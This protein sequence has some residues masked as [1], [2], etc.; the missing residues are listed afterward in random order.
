L[1]IRP[2]VLCI[3]LGKDM[4]F[5]KNK[6]EISRMKYYAI[7]IQKLERELGIKI[8]SFPEVGLLA[9]QFF[10]DNP[11]YMDKE[12]TSEEIFRM[13]MERDKDLLT[14]LYEGRYEEK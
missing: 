12:L 5:A 11:E 9:L 1:K 4:L 13:L 10:Q 6:D 8:S 3:K 2:G 7:V 14:K